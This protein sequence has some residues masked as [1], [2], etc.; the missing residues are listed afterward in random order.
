MVE[1]C[2][3]NGF[4][5]CF[6]MWLWH[7]SI[8]PF[9]IKPRWLKI[10][11]LRI[12]L[13]YESLTASSAEATKCMARAT[14]MAQKFILGSRVSSAQY[15]VSQPC[16][17]IQ[18]DLRVLRFAKTHSKDGRRSA[19]RH[20]TALRHADGAQSSNQAR[21][22]TRRVP[23]RQAFGHAT[24]ATTNPPTTCDTK[25][26]GHWSPRGAPKY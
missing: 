10:L 3:S 9:L 6:G 12:V 19:P 16:M 22:P 21:E 14:A 1:H 17:T 4:W 20:H 15:V 18:L 7:S 8:W 26:C 24:S 5:R 13:A 11:S 2:L 25:S 23:R